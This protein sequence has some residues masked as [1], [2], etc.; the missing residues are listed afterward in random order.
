MNYIDNSMK[1][2]LPNYINI[3]PMIEIINQLGN[4]GIQ[5]SIELLNM[6]DQLSYELTT[7]L[8]NELDMSEYNE[9]E[10]QID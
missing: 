1:N 2:S 5:F 9:L 3:H 8:A 6:T 10:N 7:E 4:M